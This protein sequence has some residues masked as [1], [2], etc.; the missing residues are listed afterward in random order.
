MR[1][2]G[3]ASISQPDPV[4]Q[5]SPTSSNLVATLKRYGLAGV[6]SYGVLNTLWYTGAFLTAASVAGA[7]AAGGGWNAAAAKAAKVLAMTWAGSQV[8]KVSS[9]KMESLCCVCL[10][11]TEL[12]SQKTNPPPTTPPLRPPALPPPSSSP[13]WPTA[14]ST[15]CARRCAC[16]ARRRPLPCAC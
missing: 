10:W 6:L 8:T 12:G 5:N 13:R 1:L 15:P 14:S 9:K 11:D 4:P 16:A 3:G 7:P 2:I